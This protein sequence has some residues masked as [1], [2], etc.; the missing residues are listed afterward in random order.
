VLAFEGAKTAGAT[1]AVLDLQLEIVALGIGDDALSRL[2]PCIIFR[3]FIRAISFIIFR[4]DI[5]QGSTR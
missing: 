3:F 2:T 5:M 1:G 4:G